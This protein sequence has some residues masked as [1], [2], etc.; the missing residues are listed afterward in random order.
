VVS[1]CINFHA[2]FE[3]EASL[4]PFYIQHEIRQPPTSWGIWVWFD[5]A[6]SARET[7]S[8]RHVQKQRMSLKSVE[9]LH[10]H[11]IGK[12]G[13]ILHKTFLPVPDPVNSRW[14]IIRL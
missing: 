11:G 8:E 9:G 6:I 12:E 10:S 14:R 2:Y 7:K 5:K 4:L 3:I 13:A 1:T